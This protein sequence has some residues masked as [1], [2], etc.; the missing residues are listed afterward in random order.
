MISFH[1]INEIELVPVFA[2]DVRRL[3]KKKNLWTRDIQGYRTLI[4][5]GCDKR[6]VKTGELRKSTPISRIVML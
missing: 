3:A 5:K 1:A 6:Y 2:W 4:T